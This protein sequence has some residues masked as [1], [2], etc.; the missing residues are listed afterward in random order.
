[1]TNV[2]K[3]TRYLKHY[4]YPVTAYKRNGIMD[5]DGLPPRPAQ[6]VVGTWSAMLVQPLV[7]SVLPARPSPPV[8]ARMNLPRTS[9]F[10]F[11]PFA[12]EWAYEIRKKNTHHPHARCSQ[13]WLKSSTVACTY[14]TGSQGCELLGQT[15]RGRATRAEGKRRRS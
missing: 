8:G 15:A 6:L 1:M 7:G 11:S 13:S 10:K 5:P 12:F 9:I 3:R 4:K 2:D 14:T